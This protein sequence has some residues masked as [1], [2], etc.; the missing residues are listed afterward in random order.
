MTG[1]SGR[2]RTCDPRFWST[3][4]ICTGRYR[5]VILCRFLSGFTNGRWRLVSDGYVVFSRVWVPTWVQG[6]SI[7]C[8]ER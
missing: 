2:A 7:V 1:R 3:L 5:P 6:S 8:L 4:G